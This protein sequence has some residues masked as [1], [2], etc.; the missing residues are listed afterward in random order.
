M[1]GETRCCH[2]SVTS[3]ALSTLPPSPTLRPTTGIKL[4]LFMRRLEGLRMCEHECCRV[5]GVG[6]GKR[7]AAGP[8]CF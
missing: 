8:V 3:R 1:L 7:P 2:P 4:W 5:G 6:K